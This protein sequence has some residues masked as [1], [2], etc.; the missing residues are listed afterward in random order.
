MLI[1]YFE[2]KGSAQAEIAISNI[3]NKAALNV[4]WKIIAGER[5]EYDDSRL[6]KLITM[7]DKFMNLA[8]TMLSGPLGLLPFLKHIPPFKAD[9]L[10][11]KKEMEELRLFLTETI[12]DHKK[13][14]DSANIRDYIDTFI[15]EIQISEDKNF[16]E[17]HLVICCLDMFAGGSET[18]S[19]SLMF[20]IAYMVLYPDIQEKVYQELIARVPDG[21]VRLE[22]MSALTFTDSVLV[23][24]WR[25]NPIIPTDPQRETLEN[26]KIGG[27]D[28]P[29]GTEVVSNYFAA[30][31]DENIWEEPNVFKPERHLG[32]KENLLLFGTG[33]RK[34][35]GEGLA[36]A[37][38]FLIFCNLI[39]HLRF[40][41][42]EGKK[43]D[44]EHNNCLPGLTVGP[45]PFNVIITPRH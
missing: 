16:C 45:T 11:S 23:E 20:L 2:S 24:I 21:Q 13:T 32:Q 29:A 15:N 3:F 9:F 39:K 1:N 41:C 12:E 5:Y 38:N 17:E 4:V 30:Q 28:I 8:Q 31:R 37:E 19:K 18:T 44:V 40:E 42:V 36:R 26:M 27:F 35:M 6:D 43:P 7:L 22:D 14:F 10:R 33:R 25:L 34:C